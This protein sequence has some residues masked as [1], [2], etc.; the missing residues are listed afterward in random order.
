MKKEFLITSE[1]EGMRLDA[2]LAEL[3]HASR[4]K[5]QKCFPDGRVFVNGNLCESKK[6]SAKEGDRIE[7]DLTDFSL[8]EKEME[9]IPL[10]EDIPLNI[11]YEDEYYLVINKPKGL[12]VHP[13]NGNET[14]TLVNG[15]L[16]YLGSPFLE[17][18]REV[19]SS[20]RPGIVHRIDKDTTGLIVVAKK[21]ESFISLSKQFLDHTITRKYIALVYNNFK[22][23]VGRIDEPIGR[24]PVNRLRRCVN[25]IDPK[26]SVTNYRVLER[27][28]N[29]N[30]I[31]A[32]L[33]TGR[34]HQIRVHMSH[35]GHPVVG[36]PLYGPRK[37]PFNAEGQM[38]HAGCL[39]FETLDNRYLEFSSD[40]PERFQTVLS[41]IR[42]L[43]S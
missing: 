23:D 41:K 39:G 32:I 4:S 33:E 12:V 27:L 18:M 35:I 13:G 29:Y 31:E 1:Y 37:D 19:S 24:D 11:V 3:L 14:G 34:T 17:E 5:I 38:L 40:L 30:L 2:L 25:G 26:H 43:N 20:E 28:G 9:F 36:D 6:Q 7:I 22:E 15:L 42:K 21:K 16:C 10:P 8:D